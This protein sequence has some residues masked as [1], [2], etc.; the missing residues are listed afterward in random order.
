MRNSLTVSF[1]IRPSRVDKKGEA[2]VV[3]RI[4]LNQKSKDLFT[5]VRVCPS[6][7]DGNKERMSGRTDLVR[8]INRMLEDIRTRYFDALNALAG[9]PDLSLEDLLDKVNGKSPNQEYYLLKVINQHNRHVKGRIG[10]D[11]TES[12]FEKYWI[13]ELRVT[14]YLKDSLKKRDVLLSKLDRKFIAGFFLFLRDTHKNQHNTAAKLVKN[15]K[16]VINF[17]IEQ[18]MT[19]KNPFTGFVC[20]YKETSRTVLSLDELR[21]IENK[22]F[23]IPRLELVKNLFLFQCYTGLSYVDM[24]KLTWRS[25]TKAGP[26][27]FWLELR[28][29]KTTTFVQIPLFPVSLAII[30]KYTVGDQPPPDSP[31][32]PLCHIQKM[33]SY[34]KEIADLCSITK[35]LTTHAGRRTFASTVMLNNGVQIEAVSKML[36]HTNLKTTQLYA[37]VFDHRILEQTR[38]IGWLWDG[39][40]GQKES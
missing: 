1:F 7:W 39:Q 24:A 28:R 16:R 35:R 18:G 10:I 13:L 9:V 38:R 25:V 40:P 34:L 8:S 31:L 32:L 33:N 26:G 21:R 29:T 5:Q 27:L 6:E 12:T 14:E 22:H 15:L 36:G 23:S 3:A 19:D 17:A 37:K 30:Q 2:P 20:G 11:Y 4:R